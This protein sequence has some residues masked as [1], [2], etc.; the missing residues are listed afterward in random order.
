MV[1]FEL[2]EIIDNPF[3]FPLQSRFR[4]FSRFNP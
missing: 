4:Q 2:A 3:G 1:D